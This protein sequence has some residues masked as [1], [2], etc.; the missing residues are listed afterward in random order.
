[1]KFQVNL[2]GRKRKDL[3]NAIGALLGAEV[4]YKG[5]PT[6]EYEVGQAVAS[7]DSMV[8]VSADTALAN[9]LL[10]GLLEQGFELEVIQVSSAD[11]NNLSDG[12]TAQDIGHIP[13]EA[14]ENTMSE[15]PLEE[16][17]VEE[18]ADEATVGATNE[19]ESA[20]ETEDVEPFSF[21]TP[22][23]EFVIRE[24][25]AVAA[26]AEAAG[27]GTY[28]HH[29]GRDVYIKRAPNGKTEHSKWFALVGEP[30]EETVPAVESADTGPDT[31]IAV[32]LPEKLVIQMPL[33]GFNPATLQNLCDLVSSKA[34]LIKKAIGAD[35]LP[36]A[37]TDTTVDFSWFKADT[38]SQDITA[39]T[40]FIVAMCDLAKRQKRVSAA[41]KPVDNEKL[42]LRLFMVRLGLIGSEYADTRRLLL[43]DL[44]GNS[45]WKDS[46]ERVVHPSSPRLEIKLDLPDFTVGEDEVSQCNASL[47]KQLG[48]FLLHFDD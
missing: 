34:S 45:A 19:D 13:D 35:D 46:G 14:A 5:P 26:E 3:A 36:I 30:F 1:M 6:Y 48:Y 4:T 37:I 7:R 29:E 44:P 28:F 27:Y 32:G 25:F 11:T 43:R 33:E 15:A 39:Y 40:K 22:R 47:I 31:E 8:T 12:A 41:E 18:T 9:R 20:D 23:G 16:T 42:A 2:N 24:H 38:P 21:A 17:P 10:E